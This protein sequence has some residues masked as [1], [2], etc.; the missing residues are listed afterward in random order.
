MTQPSRHELIFRRL[1]SLLTVANTSIGI[2]DIGSARIGVKGFGAHN[3]FHFAFLPSIPFGSMPASH[4][5]ISFLLLILRPPY[6]EDIT[7]HC[8]MEK[9]TVHDKSH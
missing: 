7:N 1:F 4:A 8:D 2:P 9:I 6:A 5:F 3:L